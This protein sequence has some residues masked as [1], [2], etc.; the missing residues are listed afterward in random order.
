MANNTEL[1]SRYNQ[2][3]WQMHQLRTEANEAGEAY[4]NKLKQVSKRMR[5]VNDELENVS[6][7]LSRATGAI[8]PN[9]E[10]PVGQS[11]N[12]GFHP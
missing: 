5:T 11:V 4:A 2:L 7:A 8:V 9:T 10:V 3:V 1:T 12:A 6:R